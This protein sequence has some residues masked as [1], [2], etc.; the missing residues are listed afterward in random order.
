[1]RAIPRPKP[2]ASGSSGWIVTFADLMSLLLTFFILLLSFSKM[3]L[4]KYEVMAIAM[5][6]SFGIEALTGENKAGGAIIFAEAPAIPPPPATTDE[7]SELEKEFE[8]FGDSDIEMLEEPEEKESEAAQIDP[9]I[10]KLTESLVDSLESEIL[11]NALSVSYDSNKVVVRFS[12]ATT[13]PSGSEELKDAMFP[14]LEKIEEVLATCEGE[15]TVSGYTDNLPVNSAR[16][17]SNWDLSAA[18]AVSVVHQLIFNNKVD[19]NRVSAAGRAETNPLAPND[20]AENRAKNRRVEI[21]VFDPVCEE[22]DW[23]F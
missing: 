22:S 9:S 7:Q 18:R 10:D 4:Q 13:F 20:T 8:D 6:S 16:Y 11:S 3:D 14:I 17:R 19:A 1:M 12:E 5:A 2:K 23:D 15:I 21:S